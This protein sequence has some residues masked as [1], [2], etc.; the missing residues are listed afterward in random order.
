[1]NLETLESVIRYWR[2]LDTVEWDEETL[3]ETTTFVSEQEKTLDEWK[4]YLIKLPDAVTDRYVRL[5][6]QLVK[7]GLISEAIRTEEQL[8]IKERSPA[9][10]ARN[11]KVLADWLRNH[12]RLTA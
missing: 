2:A 7:A 5:L 12:Q 6:G 9:F 11:G 8:L 4:D 1:M 10:L 3:N